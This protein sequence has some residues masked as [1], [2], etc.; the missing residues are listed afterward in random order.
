M[1]DVL[2]FKVGYTQWLPMDG[3]LPNSIFEDFLNFLKF[4]QENLSFNKI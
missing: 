2:I 3:F 4:C 1:G